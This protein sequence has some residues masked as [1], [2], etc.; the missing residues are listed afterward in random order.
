MGRRESVEVRTGDE[1]LAQCSQ[2]CHQV[3]NDG[4]QGVLKRLVVI[5][6]DD[7]NEMPEIFGLQEG[8]ELCSYKFD[9]YGGEFDP[10]L[11]R[12]RYVLYR[13]RAGADPLGGMV[14]KD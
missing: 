4:K 12:D 14:G 3:N 5:R 6:P 8:P 11:V 1:T 2:F 10:V 13:R 7:E 9:Q